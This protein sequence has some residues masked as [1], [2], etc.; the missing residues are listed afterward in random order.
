MSIQGRLRI[1]FF[2]EEN[3]LCSTPHE[4]DE[5]ETLLILKTEESIL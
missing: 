5:C 2:Y 3:F 4:A 1:Y